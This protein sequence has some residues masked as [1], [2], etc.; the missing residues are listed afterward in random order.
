MLAW[1]LEWRWKKF[2]R[3]LSGEASSPFAGMIEILEL[4]ENFRPPLQAQGVLGVLQSKH[5]QGFP[6]SCLHPMF[7]DS[8]YFSHRSLAFIYRLTKTE[9]SNVFGAL[10]H[11]QLHIHFVSPLCLLFDGRRNTTTEA[12]WIPYLPIRCC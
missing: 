8:I 6:S 9:H 1:K 11:K 5:L 10:P 2:L 3:S 12:L 7:W 4:I